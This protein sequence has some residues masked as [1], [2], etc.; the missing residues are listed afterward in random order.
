MKQKMFIVPGDI[1]KEEPP[2][3]HSYSRMTLG[4]KCKQHNNTKILLTHAGPREPMLVL[5]CCSIHFLCCLRYSC[6]ALESNLRRK[7][8]LLPYFWWC[9]V[10]STVPMSNKWGFIVDPFCSELCLTFYSSWL[11]FISVCFK[12][13]QLGQNLINCSARLN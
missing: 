4:D 11:S 9:E 7:V 5:H 8:Q 1:H 3:V 12:Q 13:D 2:Q 6:F 10:L